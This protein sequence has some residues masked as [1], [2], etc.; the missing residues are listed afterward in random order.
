MN[1]NKF[2]IRK[3]A[4]WREDSEEMFR[5]IGLRPA[6]YQDLLGELADLGTEKIVAQASQFLFDF[7]EHGASVLLER[8]EK[9]LRTIYNYRTDA[10]N[11]VCR[12]ATG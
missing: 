8:S 9:C 10:L 3:L 6:Q 12:K 1:D 7:N 4:K 5:A 2:K 11:L